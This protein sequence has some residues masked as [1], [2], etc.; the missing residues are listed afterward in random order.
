MSYRMACEY[1]ELLAGIVTLAG[2]T[3]YDNSVCTALSDAADRKLSILHIHGTQDN[4]I[5]Y[6]GGNIRGVLYPSAA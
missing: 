4:T 2:A 5:R 3:Y 1:P 6:A